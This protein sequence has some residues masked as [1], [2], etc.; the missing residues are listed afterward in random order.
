MS[1]T[2]S[3]ANLSEDQRYLADM[4]QQFAN[5]PLSA[6]SKL[7]YRLFEKMVERRTEAAKQAMGD[8]FDIR[9][10]HDVILKSGAVPLDVLAE[11][12]EKWS[13]SGS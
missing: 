4:R 1:D 9:G 10:F 6:E 3:A 2:K 7:S 12:V 11:N 8:R 13:R 5:V